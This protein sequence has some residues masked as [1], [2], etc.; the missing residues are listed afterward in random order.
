MVSP[1]PCA[2]RSRKLAP[3]M[4]ALTGAVENLPYDGA[5]ALARGLV[6]VTANQREFSMVGGLMTESWRE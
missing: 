5:A 1:V 3:V 4:R 6:L 2:A